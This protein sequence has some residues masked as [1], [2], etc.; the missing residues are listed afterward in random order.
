[1]RTFLALAA[2]L[3]VP[4]LALAELGGTYA[5]SGTNPGTGDAYNGSA[6]I[7]RTGST[8]KVVWNV[9][10]PYTGTGILNGNVLSV[11]FRDEATGLF[12][13]VTYTVSEAGNVL[14][15]TWAAYGQTKIGTETL[16]KK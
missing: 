12:G 2:F 8:Y 7:S 11:A 4:T 1:M 13:V 6:A 3:L 10:K 9:G 16:R 14:E 5:V 15:G